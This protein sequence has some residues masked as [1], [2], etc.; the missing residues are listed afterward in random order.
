MNRTDSVNLTARW[1]RLPASIRRALLPILSLALAALGLA[2]PSCSSAESR[3]YQA[4]EGSGRLS[5]IPITEGF[6][7]G[8][9]GPAVV[10]I[11]GPFDEVWIV[12]RRGDGQAGSVGAGE[13]PGTGS[14]VSA[15]RD[16][17]G[18]PT[19]AFPL[20]STDVHASL[21]GPIATVHVAQ[22]F[23]NPFADTIEAAYLFP[24]P[25]DAAVSDFVM[26]VGD[27]RIRGI[28]RE[29]EEAERIYADAR[30]QGYVAS[31]L[32]E[33]RPN[34]FMER[35]ANI[36][37]G[38]SVEV[39]LTYFNMLAYADGWYEWRFPLVVGPRYNP[40]SATHPLPAVPVGDSARRGEVGGVE[41]LAP[42]ER[43]GHTVGI[44]VAIDAG[45][46]VHDI[47][48]TSHAIASVERDGDVARVRLASR[49]AAVN[50]DFVLRYR[51]AGSEPACGLVS[52]MG[53]DGQG[54]FALTLY[55]PAA[56]RDAGRMPI[57][58][59]Y[60]IDRS[61]SMAG[62]PLEQVK[63]AVRA[64]LRR[65]RSDDRFQI[66]DF[67]SDSGGF[68]G[69][70]CRATDDAVRDANR[71]LDRLDAR[72]GTEVLVGLSK[73]L[74]LPKQEGRVQYL[75]FLSDGF[76]SNE[77]EILARLHREL[78]DR[79]VFA[80]GVGS[81]ANW[82]LIHGMADV[83]R[84]A[85]ADIG[86]DADGAEPM[87]RFMEAV[88]H[89][90]MHATS[91]EWS[92]VRVEDLWP[93][94]L[95]DLIAGRPVTVVGRYERGGEAR[96]TLRGWVRGESVSRPMRVSFATGRREGSLDRLWARAA[97]AQLSDDALWGGRRAD[98][99]H[100]EILR[101]ALRYGISS[102]LTAFVAV[103]ASRVTQGSV[104]T[105]VTQPVAMPA[106]VRYD[107]TVAPG[108]RTD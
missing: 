99:A 50:R 107:T 27:R 96:L 67:G 90:I 21:D 74:E 108:S 73:A 52:T 98:E 105:T 72:G 84:G 62:R 40:A 103:D 11:D 22:R 91:L 93:R 2:L 61:G 85:A 49:D 81:S 32:T 35:V 23:G 14:L 13:L 39:E 106:G 87:E 12:A 30:T 34:V 104:R 25:H 100:D 15:E 63:Q 86:L 31:L 76:V 97:I 71:Y 43:T 80:F 101:T 58:I 16:D 51:V 1:P 48:C 88:A 56:V 94:R 69:S 46:E 36:E 70:M 77:S 75:A 8:N 20:E 38:R 68:G 83:G 7:Q 6:L 10:S 42:G 19:R 89:P 47:E 78:G 54:Y 95:P 33:E 53:D 66:V 26:R 60:V 57:D 82:H 5:R 17:R 79:R 45:V 4:N 3:A 44:D 37:P 59:V 102:P 41:Y 65:L 9:R 64:S 29:R 18:L 55:P 28:V 92:G 24:L